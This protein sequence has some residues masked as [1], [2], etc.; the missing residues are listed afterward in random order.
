MAGEHRLS[1]GGDGWCKPRS[2][3]AGC[4]IV[5]GALAT[6]LRC[7]ARRAIRQQ[8]QQRNRTRLHRPQCRQ[9]ALNVALEVIEH[10]RAVAWNSGRASDARTLDA[11]LAIVATFRDVANVLTLGDRITAA[12]T[13]GRTFKSP[14]S[15]VGSAR[16][17]SRH[18]PK[19]RR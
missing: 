1:T 7:A 16:E 6:V 5:G 15:G 19:T 13:R 3:R 4:G 11:A 17:P 10:Y 8:S 9:R 14:G 12:S 18:I 2:V